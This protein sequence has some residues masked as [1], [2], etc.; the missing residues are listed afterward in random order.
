M[1][2]P[3]FFLEVWSILH[4]QFG[5][6]VHNIHQET[7]VWRRT[8]SNNGYHCCLTS[9]QRRQLRWRR[10]RDALINANKPLQEFVSPRSGASYLRGG[11]LSA[12]FQR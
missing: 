3:G 4:K 10:A 2:A 12:A 8:L 11:P 5:L 1:A 9:L 7:D 6:K